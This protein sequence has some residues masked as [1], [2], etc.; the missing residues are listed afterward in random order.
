MTE[1]D[2]GRKNNVYMY[3]Y[4]GHYAVRQKKK[5]YWGNN[6][7]KKFLQDKKINKNK[8]LKIS[9]SD[10]DVEKKKATEI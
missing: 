10:K 6:S 3:T 5:L 2:N 7:K 8:R 4:L 1:H 9:D